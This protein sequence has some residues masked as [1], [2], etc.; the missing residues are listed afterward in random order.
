[1]L[2]SLSWYDAFD[3][4]LRKWRWKS[5][6]NKER[7]MS[8]TLLSRITGKIMGLFGRTEK[9]LFRLIVVREKYCS[10][11]TWIVISCD[12]KP[13]SQ[14]AISQPNSPLG[15]L[16]TCS[17]MYE[18]GWHTL[19]DVWIFSDDDICIETF[20]YNIYHL[21]MVEWFIIELMWKGSVMK[22]NEL[23]DIKNVV[24][25]RKQE[26]SLTAP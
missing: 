1:M 25:C 17:F 26:P 7:L 23:I 4:M 19:S 9:I 16:L 18:L 11:R 13:A 24:Y 15:S 20:E 12:N 3:C 14:Q 5:N 22:F 21:L 10:G 8:C 2:H 6:Y